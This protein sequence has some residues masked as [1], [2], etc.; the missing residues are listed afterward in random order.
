MPLV[1][2]FRAAVL[3]FEG[4]GEAVGT[5]FFIGEVGEATRKFA[6]VFVP[7]DGTSSSEE[8]STAAFRLRRFAGGAMST[9]AAFEG[10]DFHT[11]SSADG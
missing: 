6:N 3:D 1:D 5:R 7:R 2:P 9:T 10:L 4:L 8:A 11:D